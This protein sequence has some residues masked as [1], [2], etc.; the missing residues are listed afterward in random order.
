MAKG[1]PKTMR[2]ENDIEKIIENVKGNNFSDKF[3]N[4]VRDYKETIPSR[5]KTLKTLESKITQKRNELN[6]LTNKIWEIQNVEHKIH[7]IS[8]DV[9][10]L[11]KTVSKLINKK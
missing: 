2:F 11:N 4:L 9:D 3:H 7:S 10:S 8:Q 6:T 5:T 1:K